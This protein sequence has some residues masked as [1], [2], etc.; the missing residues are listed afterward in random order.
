M[1]ALKSV[2]P[3]AALVVLGS[4]AGA[5]ASAYEVQ[6][7]QFEPGTEIA[8]VEDSRAPL[9]HVTLEFPV[10]N[11][12]PWA[13]EQHAD[14]AFDIQLYDPQ[15]SLRAR[16]DRLSVDLSVGMYAD[17]A[18]IGVDCLRDDVDA[19]LGLVRELIA[20]RDFDRAE[21]KR[22][23]KNDGLGW[24][25]SQKEP[26]F[27]IRQAA[28]RMLYDADDPRRRAYERPRA[29]IADAERLAEAR[30]IVVRL[31][32]RIV[33]FAGQIT[34]AEAE[35]LVTDLLPPVLEMAPGG[36]DPLLGPMTP[37]AELPAVQVETMP[38]IQQTFFAYGRH[39]LTYESP[40]YP[41]FMVADNVLGGHFFSRMYTALRHEGGETYGAGTI[42]RG[43]VYRE[44]YALTTFTRAENSAATEAKLRAVLTRLHEDGI[45]E[46]ERAAAVGYIQGSRAFSRQ[47]PAQILARFLWERRNE[48]PA[49]YYD[50][51]IDGVSGIPLSEINAFI[52]EF[53][54]PRQFVMLELSPA[55]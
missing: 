25:V 17:V 16:A 37:I 43:G 18:R 40:H 13:V 24:K 32:G 14:E 48:L 51:L 21:L 10:G 53:Y 44:G 34:R 20:N 27:R 4:V 11:W 26:S 2:K 33:G 8:L 28:A 7:W 45:T 5:I 50:A 35:R 36:L 22:W 54:D 9:V 52:A 31:P 15:G 29:R 41:A 19:A 49:G 3:V 38:K 6:R 42:G 47:S 46:E 23:N 39:S 55:K 12:S 30:D 1:G